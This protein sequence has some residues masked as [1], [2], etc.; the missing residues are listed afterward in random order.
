MTR[1]R[2]GESRG[3][4]MVEMLLVLPM[5]LLLVLGAVDIGR[6]LFASVA[7]EEA[8]QE[9]A[10]YAAY[11]PA[12]TTTIQARVLGSTTSDD[13]DGA[14]VSVQCF[15]SPAPGTV[16]VTTTVAYPLITPVISQLLGNPLTLSATVVATN[17]QGSCS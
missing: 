12:A 9:G 14:S 16:E 7:L 15:A 17:L 1:R 2:A 5:L 11:N 6:L 13:L 10:L 8:T 3:Q 4:A